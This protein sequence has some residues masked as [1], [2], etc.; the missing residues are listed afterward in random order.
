MTWVWRGAISGS[1]LD[2]LNCRSEEG[3][4]IDLQMSCCLCRCFFTVNGDKFALGLVTKAQPFVAL[5]LDNKARSR[6]ALF[7]HVLH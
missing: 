6:E 1:L 4:A 3:A 2:E 7:D 5:L